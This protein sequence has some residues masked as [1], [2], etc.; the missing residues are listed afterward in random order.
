MEVGE[1]RGPVPAAVKGQSDLEPTTYRIGRSSVMEA[2]LD[3]YVEKGPLKTSL[4][5]LCHA[6]G[7]E[8]VPQPEPYEAVVFHDFFEAGLRFPCVD[9]VGEVLQ[10]FNLQI[11]HLTP[12]VVARMSVFVMVL[13]NCQ[14]VL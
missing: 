10:R 4:C 5:S 11:H 2:V 7:H 12:N 6:A 1:T 14:G 13:K 3:E 8:E 9:F